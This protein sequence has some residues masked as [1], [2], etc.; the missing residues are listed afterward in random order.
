MSGQRR[1][2]YANIETAL[3]ECLV[4]AG[5]I[6]EKWA[7]NFKIGI[8]VNSIWVICTSLTLKFTVLEHNY[9]GVKIK[10]LYFITLV[11]NILQ[12]AIYLLNLDYLIKTFIVHC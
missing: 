9:K 4:F 1:R 10:I 3:S 7:I 6:E 12:S 5:N 2:R 8:R 11:C